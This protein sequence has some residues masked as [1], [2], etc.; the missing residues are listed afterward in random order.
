MLIEDVVNSL[1]FI[2]KE[3]REGVVYAGCQAEKLLY[4]LDTK[5]EK[6]GTV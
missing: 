3:H 2:V 4:I 5:N 6:I 1:N